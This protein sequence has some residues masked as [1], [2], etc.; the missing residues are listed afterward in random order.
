M[1]L[2][3]ATLTAGVGP[4][5][6]VE[7]QGVE[8]AVVK[9]CQEVEQAGRVGTARDQHEHALAD[10]EQ[11]VS[12]AVRVDPREEVGQVAATCRDSRSRSSRVIS[13]NHVSATFPCASMNTVTGSPVAP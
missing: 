9:T 4:Q 2:G 8:R 11:L 7:R 5:A 1:A 12:P 10:G 6:V 3:Q 13:P